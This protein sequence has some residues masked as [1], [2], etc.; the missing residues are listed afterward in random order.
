[1]DV[2]PVLK[3]VFGSLLFPI[4]IVPST[5]SEITKISI[6]LV[7]FVYFLIILSITFPKSDSFSI[8]IV[9]CSVCG[10]MKIGLK[11]IDWVLQQKLDEPNQPQA[12]RRNNIPNGISPLL[13]RKRHLMGA[14]HGPL[15]D[16]VMVMIHLGFNSDEVFALA[17]M[18][19]NR[20]VNTEEDADEDLIPR[21]V[22]VKVFDTEYDLP[23]SRVMIENVFF[24][25]F[26]ISHIFL[27]CAFSFFSSYFLMMIPNEFQGFSK[28]IVA[29][30]MSLAVFSM[31]RPPFIDPY[32]S[33]LN[34]M[35]ISFFR[36]FYLSLF[37][38]L[39]YINRSY[40]F[41]CFLVPIYNIKID[42][43]PI[44]NLL[45]TLTHIAILVFP[46]LILSSMIGHP[47]SFIHWVLELN[48]KFI[49]G[50]NGSSGLLSACVE[51]TRCFC[52]I[53]IYTKNIGGEYGKY[54]VA[55]VVFCVSFP[56]HIRYVKSTNIRFFILKLF[57]IFSSSILAL[58]PQYIKIKSKNTVISIV[59]VC[60]LFFDLIIPYISSNQ[61]YIFLHFRLMPPFSIIKWLRYF[62]R[63]MCIP[64][65]LHA[66]I[67]QGVLPNWLTAVII[68]YTIQ[69]AYSE[70]HIFSISLVLSVYTLPLEFCLDYIPLNIFLSMIITTELYRLSNL[71][72][73]VMRWR[74]E[75]KSQF[76]TEHPIIAH[77]TNLCLDRLLY[78]YKSF[79]KLPAAFYSTITSA[80]VLLIS[81]TPDY[82]MTSFPKPVDIFDCSEIIFEQ[83]IPEVFSTRINQNPIETPVY[84]SFTKELEK[85][86]LRY[87]SNGAL[88]NVNTGDFFLFVSGQINAMV[89]I[90]SITP[91]GVR[92]QIRGLEYFG[93]MSCHETELAAI[94]NIVQDCHDSFGMQ[95]ALKFYRSYFE[96]R[97]TD[98][99]MSVLDMSK[100]EIS[101]AF[102][103]IDYDKSTYYIYMSLCKILKGCIIQIPTDFSPK[104]SQMEQA[105]HG[106]LGILPDEAI[107]IQ[108]I[109][110]VLFRVIFEG[111]L[112]SPLNLYSLFHQKMSY[113]GTI[114]S[115]ID[116]NIKG[117]IT[118]SIHLSVAT[119]FMVSAG[120][121]PDNNNLEEMFNFLCEVENTINT[122]IINQ[123]SMELF[124]NTENC[125]ISLCLHDDTPQIVRFQ[126]TKMNWSVLKLHTE[127]IRGLWANEAYT[128]LF[129][130]H[131]IP[132]RQSIQRSVTMLRNIINQSCDYPLGYPAF[133]SP[134]L[135]SYASPFSPRD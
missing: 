43:D 107:S 53:I 117:L 88:G 67:E 3:Q 81:G 25:Q 75:I 108:L 36:I 35:S 40:S 124:E 66:I 86:L 18:I 32:S 85:Q 4:S 62:S 8:S 65:F 69:K 133:V 78:F 2:F 123:K 87:I 63:S 11:I 12:P 16:R 49:F 50:I 73:L 51:L 39:I 77:F 79:L 93:Q 1:M 105:I 112:I 10:L 97:A 109:W 24:T 132:E 115:N 42:F 59:M 29:L 135:A 122:T 56:L 14:R 80:P 113:S 46:L 121:G 90:I 116:E 102:L 21:Y 111:R 120:I 9:F 47:I 20:T 119:L 104:A 100:T 55:F 106:I 6:I 13:Y 96:L 98:I 131:Q 23:F 19:E 84:A 52:L 103:G 134:I 37:I 72:D 99:S 17:R 33:T 54:M 38:F 128:Q 28:I 82:M 130:L 83:D 118:K 91:S 15:E 64:F 45:S 58:I 94:S 71:Y 110:S 30:Y 126:R 57:S 101:S 92:F 34:D 89:Q 68:I 70:P 95:A 31:F 48:L 41:G 129:L 61:M 127:L 74:V 44:L 60:S 26:P 125:V 76:L 114:L 7:L 5:K 22:K 27:L